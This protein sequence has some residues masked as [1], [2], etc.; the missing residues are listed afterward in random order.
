MSLLHTL[1]RPLLKTYV[2]HQSRKNL[3]DYNRSVELS[4]FDAPVEVIRDQWA[5]PHIYAQTEADLFRAQGYVQA[6][7]RLWQMEMLRRVSLGTLAEAVGED[8][9]VVDRISRS[10]GFGRQAAKDAQHSP[11]VATLI[12]PYVEGVNAFLAQKD[13]LPPEY[14]LLGIE[15]RSWTVQDVF[16]VGRFLGL[17]MS[18]GWVH[19]VER[20]Q[21]VQ[22]YG[23]E[24]AQELFPA[25][26]TSNPT[27]LEDGNV[28][29]ER[30]GELLKAFKGPYLRPLEGSNNWVVAPHKM[31]TGNAALCN[32]LHLLI[33]AP[34]IW[35]EN[36]LHAASGYHVTGASLPGAPMVLIGHNEDIAWGMTLSYADVQDVYVEEFS[37]DHPQQYRVGDTWKEATIHEEYIYVKGKKDP[38]KWLVKE[39][40][41]G[42]VIADLEEGRSL[43]LASRA[44]QDNRMFDGFYGLNKA[45][46]WNDFVAAGSALDTPCLNIVYADTNQN[47]GYY[48]VGQV[49]VRKAAEGLL[50]RDGSDARYDW[51]HMVPFEEMPHAFNPPKGYFYTCNNKVI[52]DDFP[53]DLGHIW[54]NG[55]RAARLK[56][57]LESKE[58]YSMADFM[59]WQ[60][61]LYCIPGMVF[62]QWVKACQAL[63]EY[64]ALPEK[65]RQMAQY[66]VDWDG[67]LTAQ[68]IGGTIYQQ[69]KLELGRLVFE[70]HDVVRGQVT[71]PNIEFYMLSEFF[72]YDVP[73]LLRLREQPESNWWVRS[74]NETMIQALTY[75]ERALRERL[76]ADIQQWCWGKWHPFIAKHT[77]GTSPFLTGIWDVG[78]YALGGDTDTLCQQSLVPGQEGGDHSMVAASFRQILDLGDW[79]KGVCIAPLGQSGNLRSV[80]YQDQLEDWLE[81]RFKPMLWSRTSV[82]EK[83]RYRCFLGPRQ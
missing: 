70:P 9:L 31:D 74:P 38:L 79:D 71:H 61:D 50:P 78:P 12:Q 41:H 82:E 2:R 46:N 48:M 57:L 66:L 54:M 43:A 37:K 77:L 56:M 67:I 36:H 72:G 69:L 76:G 47:I 80:H 26:P 75:T 18:Q 55:Y 4:I 25:Y 11:L 5:V 29:F 64:Q 45:K 53:H 3:P 65:T 39:T 6:Q 68:S 27:S 15:P 21:L 62:A 23:L 14:K 60:M 13:P 33:S 1:L 59:D 81:G 17:Q 42:P 28:T 52:S 34:N 10:M 73:A 32:D 35:Y 58:V 8:G 30:I 49:P 63:P 40:H 83:Q 20:W 22:K 19:E 51:Q 7:D 44:I 24:R 16:A